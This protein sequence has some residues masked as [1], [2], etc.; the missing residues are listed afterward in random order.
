MTNI[1]T[2]Y[3]VV[4]HSGYGY[5]GNPQFEH[6]VETRGL[7]AVGEVKIVERSGGVVF[8]DYLAAEQ[9]AEKAN[10]PEGN[11]SIIPNAKGS[12]SHLRIDGLRIYKPVRYITG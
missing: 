12:F 11:Q 6:A 5:N 2:K 3:T 10:Y 8:D 1:A 7:N 4:Q 9:F